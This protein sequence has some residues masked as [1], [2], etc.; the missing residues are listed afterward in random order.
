MNK[1]FLFI[2]INCSLL[3][4]NCFA[5]SPSWVWGKDAVCSPN[6]G[7]LAYAIAKDNSGH[8]YHTG[9][10]G[11]S[12]TFGTNTYY[13]T[14]TG[15]S[16]TYLV[17]YDTAGN[18][19]WAR[20]SG[21]PGAAI[22]SAIT[23]DGAS[24]IYITGY[25]LGGSVSFGAFTLDTTDYDGIFM[26][27][28]D[29][30]GNVLWAVICDSSSIG[31]PYGIATDLANNVY[32]TGTIY[33]PTI[34]FGPYSLTNNGLV[35]YF[36]VK[37]DSSAHVIWARKAGETGIDKTYGIVTDTIGNE[38]ITGYFNSHQI[39]IGPDTL[40]NLGTHNV[41]IAKYDSSGNALWARGGGGIYGDMGLS[42]ATDKRDNEYVTG[43]FTS[44]T[45]NFG[46]DTLTTPGGETMF[47]VKYDASGNVQWATSSV[48]N[49][50]CNCF[51]YNVAV[52]LNSNPV[53][54]GCLGY[55]QVGL[56]TFDTTALNPP[57]DTHNPMYIVRYNSSGHSLWGKIL[58]IGGGDD[59]TNGGVLYD[60]NNIYICA[61][62]ETTP[63][64]F[65]NDSLYNL[66]IH[67]P[68]LAKLE[69]NG[70][71]GISN[72]EEHQ[73]ISIYPNP[74]DGNFTIAY[75]L[76]N[77]S[78]FSILNSQFIIT[79]VMGRE[80]HHQPIT[81]NSSLLIQINISDLNN[82]IYFWKMISNNHILDNGKIVIIK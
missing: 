12:I 47:L 57:P 18:L 34:K 46:N 42:I 29:S 44:P 11:D 24:N 20:S 68:F 51:P 79:D 69:Y 32:L 7:G 23:T 5:Q 41:F 62:F 31:Y 35:N 76:S 70:N 15:F 17:K 22:V 66:G 4:I 56:V 60:A 43:Q 2:I 28:Y 75:H 82:G 3:T 27:K 21:G 9:I 50:N 1:A 16:A 65:N 40:T 73:N 36:V 54:I 81:P 25:Y 39:V 48:N 14:D 10:F 13:D 58:V 78:Q 52:D 61:E 33:S 38:Y 67:T 26:A 64:V 72:I 8:I 74:N 63:L 59:N 80:V 77:N 71:V 53:V 45:I 55:P 49:F 30:A 19:I 37:Y 6:G